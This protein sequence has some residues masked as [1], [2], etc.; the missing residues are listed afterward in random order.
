[1]WLIGWLDWNRSKKKRFIESLGTTECIYSTC[2]TGSG[3]TVHVVPARVIQLWEWRVTKFYFECS[4]QTC[5]KKR[6]VFLLIDWLLDLCRLPHLL[7]CTP[8]ITHLLLWE[9]MVQVGIIKFNRECSRKRKMVP[10]LLCIKKN[11]H[12]LL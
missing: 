6:I 2:C 4:L 7:V 9:R 12:S 5:R 11:M 8:R 1:M 10:F 3:H